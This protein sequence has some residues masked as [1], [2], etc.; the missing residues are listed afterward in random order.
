MNRLVIPMLAAL[1]TGISLVPL[2]AAE[3]SNESA[4]DGVKLESPEDYKRE[5]DKAIK[6]IKEAEARVKARIQELEVEK[7]GLEATQE[8]L[9]AARL[10]AMDHLESVDQNGE[11]DW[12]Q[13][14]AKI[15]SWIN[16]VTDND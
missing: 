9:E 15:D 16:D 7:A 4:L 13:V 12:E 8:K 2:S 3:K 1:L 14:K 11:S 5:L 6:Q 10:E